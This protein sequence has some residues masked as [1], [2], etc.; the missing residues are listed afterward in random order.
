MALAPTFAIN[1]MRPASDVQSP[2]LQTKWTT[3]ILPGGLL[4]TDNA[5][6]LIVNPKAS[7]T[8]ATRR[9]IALPMS[10]TTI[11]IRIKYA[12]GANTSTTP[13]MNV[14]V[15]DGD[16]NSADP[17]GFMALLINQGGPSL[18]VG[19]EINSDVR[20][21]T[22]NYSA[23]SSVNV[24]DLFGHSHLLIGVQT[25][26]VASAGSFATASLEIKAY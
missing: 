5:G 24:S 3:A 20:D 11:L 13:V 14:F 2:K 12:T 8:G 26:A 10:A 4:L 22:F 17:V 16:P 18:P 19:P 6:S 23:Y 25:A 21:G 9:V 7:I 1:P 15:F